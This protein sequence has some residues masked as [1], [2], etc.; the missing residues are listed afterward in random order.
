MQQKNEESK[1]LRNQEINI[2]KNRECY[3]DICCNNENYTARG[4]SNHLKTLKHKTLKHTK[5]KIGDLILSKI[6]EAFP[7]QFSR[8]LLRAFDF[9]FE[10]IF[11]K[12][13]ISSISAG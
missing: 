8:C 10:K 13:F 7:I 3:C 1:L 2:Q 11:L 5:C 4:K 12:T 9:Q 6:M